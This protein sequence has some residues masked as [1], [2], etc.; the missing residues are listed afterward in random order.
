MVR[1]FAQPFDISE[2]T[3]RLSA[4]DCDHI[5]SLRLR[6]NESFIVCDGNGVEYICA[7]DE[8]QTSD[9]ASPGIGS[10]ARIIER[11]ESDA[12]PTIKCTVYIA[13]SKGERLDY[14]VQKSVELGAYKIITYNS[15]R[16]VAA[17]KN[18]P[19]KIERLQR[20]ALETAKQS[21]RG[22]IPE[23]SPIGEFHEA[24]DAAAK[25]SDLAI[26]CYENERNLRLNT[27]L[28]EFFTR[29]STTDGK[30]N[31]KRGSIALIT[32]PEGGFEHTEI[33]QAQSSN[34]AIVS[35]GPRILRSETAPAAALAAI[36]YHTGD[37]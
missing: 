13:Y 5:R 4:E 31:D 12:E 9:T 23:V 11:K 10:I 6:P 32:G 8:R 28:E 25:H 3:I 34:I 26:L 14:A 30:S 7:L 22:I 15:K 27:V 36:M 24:V 2:S 37:L 21:G 16:C 1:F 29:L 33:K 19:K 20:I 35:L 17:P 18:I